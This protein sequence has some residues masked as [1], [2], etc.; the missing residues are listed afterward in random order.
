[1]NQPEDKFKAKADADKY[2]GRYFV[3]WANA[4]ILGFHMISGP[5]LGVF[6]GYH[7]DKWLDSK[8]VGVSIGLFLGL[9][10][11]GLNMYRD[12]RRILHEQ[13]NEDAREKLRRMGHSTGGNADRQGDCTTKPPGS[14]DLRKG[15]ISGKS[16]S[17]NGQ[18][19]DD[20]D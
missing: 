3:T 5:L 17:Y 16:A 7:L 6:L 10:A 9:V 19:D 2:L 20:D 12:M 13:A 14:L 18:D 1:M 8:P 4:G 15:G 11:G